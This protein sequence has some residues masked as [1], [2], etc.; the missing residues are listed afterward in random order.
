MAEKLLNR[1]EIVD[2]KEMSIM[3]E[4]T[5]FLVKRG[6][7]LQYTVN[8]RTDC[9]RMIRIPAGAN[10]FRFENFEDLG[11]ILFMERLAFMIYEETI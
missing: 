2:G 7:L 11:G 8:P 10:T 5:H 4:A 3:P 1:V 9:Y 6:K